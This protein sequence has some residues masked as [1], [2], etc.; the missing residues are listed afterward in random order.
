MF[1]IV[2]HHPPSSGGG[3][4]RLVPCG[5]FDLVPLPA[6]VKID[7]PQ[8]NLII[9]ACALQHLFCV[10]D[11]C[12]STHG[13]HAFERQPLLILPRFAASET[14]IFYLILWERSHRLFERKAG[15]FHRIT[16]HISITLLALPASL[17][18]H[19]M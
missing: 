15:D 7:M 19:T 3:R 6:L 5:C 10:R 2:R 12:A 8:F 11:F 13:Q 16:K 9:A 14:D 17:S 4:H 18:S 1:R